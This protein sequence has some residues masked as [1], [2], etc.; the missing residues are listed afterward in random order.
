MRQSINNSSD[1][2][3]SQSVDW[4]CPSLVPSCSLGKFY[5]C[6]SFA[7]DS[8]HMK[9]DPGLIPFFISKIL[10]ST[11]T[12]IFRG[13]SRNFKGGGGGGARPPLDPPLTL[14]A[15]SLISKP[16]SLVL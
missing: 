16:P 6:T 4:E 2:D 14:H 12:T 9:S 5:C 13:G 7:L 8:A 10:N 1:Y 11:R 3:I 15:Q